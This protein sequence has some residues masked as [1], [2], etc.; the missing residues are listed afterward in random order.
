MMRTMGQ[1][2]LAYNSSYSRFILPAP[3]SWFMSKSYICRPGQHLPNLVLDD[4]TKLYKQV[5]PARHTWICFNSATHPDKMDHCIHVTPGKEQTSVPA[6][7][8]ETLAKPQVILVCPDLFVAAVDDSFD[9]LEAAAKDVFGTK[10]YTF[11]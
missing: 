9:E 4:G 5:D 1:L 2:D 8:E 3:T 11:M 10:C 7:P 6:I